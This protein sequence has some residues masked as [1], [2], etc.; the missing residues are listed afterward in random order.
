MKTFRWDW[1]KLVGRSETLLWLSERDGDIGKCWASIIK[2]DEFFY[3]VVVINK[4]RNRKFTI[5]EPLILE[6]AKEAVLKKLFED[7]VI[8]DQDELEDYTE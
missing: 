1:V 5:E 2:E 6:D 4:D 8:D 7:G 3:R